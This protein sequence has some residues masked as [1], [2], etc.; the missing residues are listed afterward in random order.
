MLFILAQVLGQ[1]IFEAM[2]VHAKKFGPTI[3]QTEDR[4]LVD[5]PQRDKLGT[6]DVDIEN[7]FALI[8]EVLFPL[9]DAAPPE[10]PCLKELQVCTQKQ[11]WKKFV[12]IYL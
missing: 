2:S 6:Y 1:R 4:V 5:I 7:N 8:K 10:I 12:S 3:M 11:N 9:L